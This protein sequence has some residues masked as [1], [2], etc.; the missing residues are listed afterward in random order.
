MP[1]LTQTVRL[2]EFYITLSITPAC[3]YIYVITESVINIVHH[4][5]LPMMEIHHFLIQN[6]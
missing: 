1:L 6:H 2:T 4:E 5:T 3:S